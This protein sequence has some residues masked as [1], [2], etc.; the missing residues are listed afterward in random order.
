LVDSGEV[1]GIQLIKEEVGIDEQ[2][3]YLV[4]GCAFVYDHS[5]SDGGKITNIVVGNIYTVID[6]AMLMATGFVFVPYLD[7]F[8]LVER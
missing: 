2:G 3:F 6:L 7:H 1:S 4:C 5:A 8:H